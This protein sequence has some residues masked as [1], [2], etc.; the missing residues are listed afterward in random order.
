M[1]VEEVAVEGLELV[2]VR[3]STVIPDRP[4]SAVPEIVSS[5]FVAATAA[6]AFAD[7]EAAST[8]GAGVANGVFGFA[9]GDAT[10]GTLEAIVCPGEGNDESVGLLK[11][12]KLR[13]FAF[14]LI[15][16]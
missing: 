5:D 10:A 11:L 14:L 8:D 16:G 6:A 1:V 13:T 15:G 9:A 12:D 7:L 4:P 2:F 3:E